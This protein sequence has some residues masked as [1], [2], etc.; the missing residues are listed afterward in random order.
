[1]MQAEN[2]VVTGGGGF[3]GKALVQALLVEGARV[4]VIGRN[5]YPDLEAQGVRCLQGDICD[6]EFLFKV[7]AGCTT[8]FHV[9]AKAGIWGPKK[10]YFVIN[11]LGTE[12]VLRACRHNQVANLVYTSTPS[13][14]FDRKNIEAG[15]ESLPYAHKTLCHYAASKIAAEKAVLAANAPELRTVAIRPHLVWGPGDRNLIPRLVERG[16]A[17]MLKVVGS[18][19]NRVDIAYI[20]NVVHLHML[21]AKNLQTTATAAGEAFFI[22]QNDPV[23]LW[24]WI[25]ELF[26]RMN[27]NPVKSRVPFSLAYMVGACL[28]LRGTLLGQKEEPKMTRFLAH[29]L[30]HSHWFSHRKA[31][32]ILGYREKVSS[33]AGMERLLAWMHQK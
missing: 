13:V 33:E 4:T 14:V 10:D 16:R 15:D 18:G 3:I 27:I 17:G 31:E 30:S 12:N 25:N 23:V 21:A 22:G 28:E 26:A 24:D 9:A 19:R 11:T 32:N 7:F 8:A 20:D 1:M 5:P 2:V 6:Q 29:Q